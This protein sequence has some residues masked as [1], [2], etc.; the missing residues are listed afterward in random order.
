M[1]NIILNIADYFSFVLKK[2]VKNQCIWEI[3]YLI[4][5]VDFVCDILYSHNISVKAFFPPL[6]H[7]QFVINVCFVKTDA[8]ICITEYLKLEN[9]EL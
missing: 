7:E 4:K 1:V 8:V 2:K 6:L 5:N 9:Q 3:Q